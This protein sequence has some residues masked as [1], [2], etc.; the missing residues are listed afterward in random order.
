MPF[1]SSYYNDSRGSCFGW[2]SWGLTVGDQREKTDKWE[3]N[4]SAEKQ[5]YQQQQIRQGN[6]QGL[7]T[8]GVAAGASS[9]PDW[10]F[11]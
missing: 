9:S 11:T 2:D 1:E 5:P 7:D 8:E 10:I 4:E 3:V 6:R